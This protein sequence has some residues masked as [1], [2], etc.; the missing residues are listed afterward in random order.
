MKKLRRFTIDTRHWG[1]LL[2]LRPLPTSVRDGDTMII[3]PWGELAPLREEPEFAQMLP[4]VDGE[5]FSHALHGHAKPL[6]EAL[7]PEPEFQLRKL[8]DQYKVCA[9]RGECVM[10]DAKRCVPGKKLPECW[11]PETEESARRAVAV[12]TLAWAEG[13]YVVIVEGDEFSL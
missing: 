7:G 4:V 8:P 1:T 10:Y 11:W 9:L 5:T 6:V 2:I 12:V 13:R 3:D